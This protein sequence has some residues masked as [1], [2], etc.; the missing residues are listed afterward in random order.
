MYFYNPS[1]LVGLKP[2][3]V[4]HFK[5]FFGTIIPFTSLDC[6]LET[7]QFTR[8]RN[9]VTGYLEHY[10]DFFGCLLM[11]LVSQANNSVYATQSVILCILPGEI[12]SN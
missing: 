3:G 1:S 2:G 12:I 7:R 10:W 4:N 9:R 8:R 11:N 6:E 5:N